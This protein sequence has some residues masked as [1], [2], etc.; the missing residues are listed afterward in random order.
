M[1][2][3]D[4]WSTT[5][6]SKVT[7]VF[8]TSRLQGVPSA[9]E[10]EICEEEFSTCESMQDHYIS[11][12]DLHKLVEILTVM[13]CQ[14]RS[15]TT[16]ALDQETIELTLE[17]H[18]I[19]EE[20]EDGLGSPKPRVRRRKYPSGTKFEC[21]SCQKTFSCGGSLKKHKVLHSQDKPFKC[22][23]CF[24]QFNQ[25]RDLKGHTMQNHSSERPH[26]CKICGKGFVH[27]F[28]LE[29][30]HSYHNGERRF[31]CGKCG[32]QFQS[33]SVLHK[34]QR[35]HNSERP[36][37]CA[38]CSKAFTVV[39][40]LRAH[41]KLVH[42]KANY[43]SE[44]PVFPAKSARNDVPKN[45]EY[46]KP[47]EEA[48]ELELDSSGYPVY[49][50][51]KPVLRM[52]KD[53]LTTRTSSRIRIQNSK[54]KEP[55]VV[56]PNE[57]ITMGHLI[58]D[59]SRM[60]QDEQEKLRIIRDMDIQQQIEDWMVSQ[61]VIL[62]PGLAAQDAVLNIPKVS[63][64]ASEHPGQS[65]ELVV[66]QITT[67]TSTHVTSMNINQFLL[68]PQEVVSLP[69]RPDPEAIIQYVGNSAIHPP[70]D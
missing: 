19:K 8:P 29:E 47:H 45:Y 37:K 26:V 62:G 28:Y 13:S 64:G 63:E 24:K 46:I 34:H 48:A 4:G 31:Q 67:I 25:K 20:P 16:H 1:S 27:K 36:F 40:D 69:N 2:Q 33:S 68:T 51:P 61:G 23:I 56:A 32:K 17:E 52:V 12:Y 7:T 22:D 57:E 10:L 18:S 44:I 11:S 55:H 38:Q 49:I 41:I 21:D 5:E 39:T 54:K 30:H 50:K 14:P 42:Q 70:K 60:P 3:L 9:M 15:E 59:E 35:R 53:G 65:I 66:P 43:D 6:S 58:S